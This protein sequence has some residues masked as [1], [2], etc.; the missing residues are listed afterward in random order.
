MRDRASRVGPVRSPVFRG[1]WTTGFAVSVGGGRLARVTTTTD[2]PTSPPATAAGTPAAAPAAAPGPSPASLTGLDPRT[3]AALGGVPVTSP[4]EIAAACAAARD[5]FDTAGAPGASA[6]AALLTALADG[7][8]AAADELVGTADAETALGEVRL[9]GEVAR[10]AFQLRAFAGLAG[11]AALLEP[12]IDTPDPARVPPRAGQ[13]SVQ[14]PL[15]PV[16][17][18]AASNF[19]FA[20]GVLGGDTASALAAGCP[21]V[22]EAHPA[23]PAT[24]AVLAR[25]A[26]TAVAASPVP[27]AWLQVVQGAGTEA[28]Q[29][30]VAHPGIA[31]VG[32]TG[33]LAGG[34]AL[35]AAAARR[36]EPIPVYAEMGSLNPVFVGPGAA[37]ERA[38]EI[39][40]GWVATLVANAGQLCTKPGLLVL[41][42]AAAAAVV[43]AAVTAA[44]AEAAVPPMLAPRLQDALRRRWSEIGEAAAGG[45]LLASATGGSGPSGATGGADGS[46]GDDAPGVGGTWQAAGVAVVDVAT[47]MA[48][49][50]LLEEAFG[51]VGVLAVA[52][53]P[54]QALAL[55]AVV[56][57]S[58]TATLQLGAA[59]DAWAAEA[60][61]IL[62][63][64]AGRVVVDAWPT[65]VSVGWAT[66]H[67]GPWPAT[68][69]PATTSVGL[70]AARRFTRPVAYQGLPDRL[71]PAA[72]QDA[73]P[74]ALTRRVDGEPTTAAVAPPPGAA[75]VGGPADTTGPATS[76]PAATST[77]GR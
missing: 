68:S 14:V 63:R 75:P 45:D 55:A 58:L 69:A 15:G 17:V 31:A 41:P 48:A 24:S 20:F 77:T 76:A 3:G 47:V 38:A 50:T 18:F 56:P 62:T 19:P 11:S 40:R 9:R 30:L 1:G 26:A 12:V 13:R 23:Q 44:L 54:A 42:D 10:T 43:T 28:G 39:A 5:A 65:G 51:P 22:A 32:F 57:G 21:V 27:S 49:P 72:L 4:A 59:D 67:G 34:S 52:A 74:L 46:G 71:L 7:V 25:I 60:L 33:S 2:S 61:R 70:G 16:A 6:T 37:A 29:A 53:D 35:L 8:A 73:N 66:V 64:R 36:P